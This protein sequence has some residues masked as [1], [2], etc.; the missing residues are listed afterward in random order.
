MKNQNR[1]SRIN[2]LYTK[3]IL[4]SKDLSP[5]YYINLRKSLILEKLTGML[6]SEVN[7]ESPD[8]SYYTFEYE[9]FKIIHSILTSD[10]SIQNGIDYIYGMVP[11]FSEKD[12]KKI[13]ITRLTIKIGI[14]QYLYISCDQKRNINPEIIFFDDSSNNEITSL[15]KYE[16]KFSDSLNWKEI[17]NDEIIIKLSPRPSKILNILNYLGDSINDS[18]LK[19]EDSNIKENDTNDSEYSF[20]KFFKDT[21]KPISDEIPNSIFT[22]PRPTIKCKDGFKLSVQASAYNSCYPKLTGLDIYKSFEVLSKK[23]IEEFTLYLSNKYY[24]GSSNITNKIKQ[25]DY[26]PLNVLEDFIESHGG[27]DKDATMESYEKNRPSDL[28]RLSYAKKVMEHS[29]KKNII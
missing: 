19:L 9:D 21:N 1:I 3:I 13:M 4:E 5:E 27:I 26:V 15:D 16:N 22:E 14:D 8:K 24:L 28:K 11:F 7:F 2:N 20:R 18:L 10:K 25:Y 17:K 29:I 23:E 6:T 12:N